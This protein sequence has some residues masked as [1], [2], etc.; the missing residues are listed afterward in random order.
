MRK[1]TLVFSDSW[2]FQ[3]ACWGIQGGK[4]IRIFSDCSVRIENS[5]TR[6]NHS[7][8]RS[9]PCDAEWSSRVTEY[10]IRIE[11]PLLILFLAYSS[12]EIE[13]R[14]EYALFCQF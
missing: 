6:N 2:A 1:G 14:L 8:S 7:A 5:V 12:F 4:I 11:Q 10:S 13:L 9:K 3:L